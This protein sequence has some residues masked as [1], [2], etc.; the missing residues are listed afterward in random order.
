MMKK[1][2]KKDLLYIFSLFV[3]VLGFVF[4]L[5]K[6]GYLFGSNTDWENQHIIIPEYFRTLFYS[7]GKLLSTLALNL[8]MGENIFYF[9]YYG[10]LSPIIIISYLFPH[11]PMYV[12]I[13]ASA[14]I[15]FLSSIVMIYYWLKRKYNSNIAFL[16]SIIF[17]LSG[18]MLFQSHRHVMFVIYMPF[19]IGAIKSIDGYFSNKKV[20]SLILYI[21][22]LIMTSYYYSISGIIVLGIYT[23]YHILKEKGKLNFDKFKPLFK[24]IYF[25][26]IAILLSATLLLPTIYALK[27]GRLETNFTQSIWQ[28]LIPKINLKLSFYYSYSLGLT[29]IY[30]IIFIA[31][32][33][34]K[35]R[36]N[37]F[38]SIILLICMFFPIASYLLNGLMYVDGK[39]FI[40]FLPIAILMICEFLNNIYH[41]EVNYKK[42]LMIIIPASMLI[43]YFCLKESNINLLAVDV[44]IN[45][46]ILGLIWKFK[47]PHL[48]YIPIVLICLYSCF[49]LNTNNENYVLKSDI[50]TQNN[51]AYYNLTTDLDEAYRTANNDMLLNNPNK[52]YNIN[53]NT[54]TMY[55][56]SA[57]KYYTN[58]VR[59]IFQNEVYN[60]DNLTI[61]QS[62][63][64]LFNI[65]SGTKYLITSGKPLLGYNLIKTENNISL[66]END[67]VLPIGYASSKIMSKRE[68]D[69]LKY[70]YTIDA[71][72]NYTIVDTSL[73]NVYVSNVNN[74][75]TNY[76]V[77]EKE[78]LQI[79]NNNGH[80]LIKASNNAYLKLKLDTNIYNKVLIIKFKMNKDKE[81]NGCST[82]IKINGINNSLSCTNWKYHN[83]NDTFEYVISS[84]ESFNTL[85][86]NFTSGEY[87]ISDIEL[88]TINY[89]KIKTI[90]NN[91]SE[92]VIDKSKSND[93]EI[94]G[95]INAK[96]NGYFKLTIPYENKGYKIYVDDVRVPKV[97]TDETFLGCAITKGNHTIKI[98]YTIPYLKLGLMLSIIEVVL[99]LSVIFYKYIA[100]PLNII[101][102]RI[103]KYLIWAIKRS[104]KYLKENKG[105]IY[106][107]LSMFMLDFALRLFYNKSV[108]F[109]KFY[110]L[111]PNLFSIIWIIFILALTKALKKKSGKTLYLVTYIFSLV[112]FIVHAVYYSYFKLFFDWSVLRVAGEGTEYYDTVIANI[113]YWVVIVVLISIIL[114][115]IGLKKIKFY[116]HIKPFRILIICAAFLL[117]HS[118]LPLAYGSKV[119]SVEWDDWR[120]VRSIYS[121]F[122]D[123]NKSMMISGMYEYN[124]RNFYVNYIRN[125]NKLSS[126]EEKVLDD[127]FKN[128]TVK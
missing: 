39:C 46:V 2:N 120:N 76:N 36:E 31:N 111:I 67:D 101:Y 17:T 30:F 124:I 7:N 28:L 4:Y 60:K 20:V 44:F 99:L 98:T 125:N 95:T 11:I 21:F 5:F 37:I 77:L 106:L 71:L 105:Y 41:K 80:Y 27:N 116:D 102:E 9:S 42:L 52:I 35:K 73:D 63:N 89:S 23:L 18:P 70:P 74:Y 128:S 107:F 88:Y 51:N 103:K 43:L 68:F 33:F 109:Y 126:K 122:N 64:L 19:L 65:Y 47:K 72:L 75:K 97:L 112:M 57:N 56:S 108:D 113:K 92:F 34:T 87:D 69:T 54:T 84:N 32:L 12:Y 79:T 85:D 86:L 48:I 78:K 66:Y 119:T 16:G 83:H 91:I 110:K 81:G 93:K 59:N 55:S 40:P 22:L 61:T 100:K 1:I 3:L 38:L 50:D 104:W 58:F 115:I 62:S 118:G 8:G 29:F 15:M 114:T 82:D 123:N 121:S 26:I 10:L 45:I 117:L 24:I 127:N 14:I 90:K 25:V 6:K 13:L 49:K 94:V 96:D 53:Q